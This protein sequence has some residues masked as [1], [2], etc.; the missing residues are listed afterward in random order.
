M[1]FF[2]F[3]EAKKVVQF[4]CGGN[5]PTFEGKEE[6]KRCLVTLQYQS[7]SA[8][9]LWAHHFI[10]YVCSCQSSSYALVPKTQWFNQSAS[11]WGTTGTYRL[12]IDVT[13]SYKSNNS[14]SSRPPVT[15]GLESG[16]Y[17]KEGKER[18]W[19]R[20]RF[21][22]SLDWLQQEFHLPTGP[23]WCYYSPTVDVIGWS[24]P[25]DRQMVHPVTWLVLFKSPKQFP[26]TTSRM[27]LCSSCYDGGRR[28]TEWRLVSSVQSYFRIDCST[29]WL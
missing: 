1:W 11:L 9:L 29:V 6:K 7:N 17:W 21:W 15:S 25:L 22:S 28:A 27:V 8:T 13:T 20:A 24:S 12:S 14:S 4:P 2:F 19:W 3:W 16:V 5:F 26:R 18:P 23:H 10:A